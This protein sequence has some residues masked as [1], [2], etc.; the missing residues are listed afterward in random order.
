MEA[1]TPADNNKWWTLGAVSIAIF[2]LLL[3]ITVV[4]V[5]LPDIRR[6]LNASFTDLQWVVDAYS[7]TLAATLLAFGAISDLVGRR[8]IFTVGLGVFI[9][10]S[11]GCGLAVTVRPDLLARMPAFVREV[12]GSGITVGALAA[13]GLN[14]LLPGREG[15][16]HEGDEPAGQGVAAASASAA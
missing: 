16:A 13:V 14:L 4:N 2:M 9:T 1:N 8:L 6:S 3:D 7:L 15:Q 11:L 10:A 12:F 5:A